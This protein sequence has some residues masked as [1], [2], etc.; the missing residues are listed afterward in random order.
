MK[1]NFSLLSNDINFIFITQTLFEISYFYLC[2]ISI[3]PKQCLDFAYFVKE[4][5]M[6]KPSIFPT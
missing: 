5:R 1:S 6:K 3:N 4:I 2:A